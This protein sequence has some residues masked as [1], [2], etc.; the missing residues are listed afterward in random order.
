MVLEVA[1]EYHLCDFGATFPI[2]DNHATD[3][4]IRHRVIRV[5]RLNTSGRAL[6]RRL[7]SQRGSA[8]ISG[9]WVPD[10]KLGS[11]EP[12]IACVDDYHSGD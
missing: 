4:P 12:N 6:W 9:N 5:T 10:S 1:H 8:T 7:A 11:V 2:H 3:S